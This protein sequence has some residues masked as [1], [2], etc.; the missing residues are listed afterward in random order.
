MTALPA[1]AQEDFPPEITLPD[2]RGGR[3]RAK[4]LML[5]V[6]RVLEPG[7]LAALGNAVVAPP[8]RLLQIRAAHHQLARLI[9]EGRELCDISLITGYQ[10]AYISGLQNDPAFQELLAHYASQRELIFVDAMEQLRTLGISTLQELQ[11]RLEKS[12]EKFSNRELL[13]LMQ[14]ALVEPEAIKAGAKS[15]GAGAPAVAVQVSFV[16]AGAGV[17][18]VTPREDK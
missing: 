3:R 9:C 11:D 7:D 16:G 1:T 12:P 15:A 14:K 18:D 6:E 10:P 13:E 4:P 8:Q 2:A 5:E 17:I